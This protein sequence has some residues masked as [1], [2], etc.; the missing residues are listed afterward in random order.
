MNRLQND[1]LRLE[2]FDIGANPASTQPAINITASLDTGSLVMLPGSNNIITNSA[3]FHMEKDF[4]TPPDGFTFVIE[5][6]NVDSLIRFIQRGWRVRVSLNN[7]Y[8]MIGYVYHINYSY[9]KDGTRLT[10][11]CKDLLECLAQATVY[12]NLGTTSQTNYHFGYSATLQDCLQDIADAFCNETGFDAI[13]VTADNSADLKTASGFNFG[14]KGTTDTGLTRSLNHLTT[15]YPGESHLAYMNR[16]AQHAGR[17]LKMSATDPSTIIC[18]A[19]TYDRLNGSPFQLV[20]YLNAP[21]N[22]ENNIKAA[23]YNF[24]WDR[25]PTVVITDI[26]TQGDDKFY[27]GNVKGVAINEL[28]GYPSTFEGSGNPNPIYNVRQAITVLTANGNYRDRSF[29]NDL[30]RMRQLFPIDLSTPLNFPY[31]TLDGSAHNGDEAIYG[32]SQL[33][34]QA[35]DQYLE[36][37][38]KVQGW[39]YQGYVWQP[40]TMVTVID[41]GLNPNGTQYTFPMW[42]RKI[43]YTMS[44][45][46]G[47]E[48]HLTCTLPFT[49]SYQI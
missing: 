48:T 33:L 31:Y 2:F 49:H 20:H 26:Q 28:T 40:D 44:K 11:E 38:Y 15:P 35:Q 9:D 17:N 1:T 23:S 24:N 36:V 45:Q 34:A 16:L 12:P 7:K 13:T 46:N 14:L 5:D 19:P 8:N 10:I 32:A 43:N 29:N 25:Q 22:Q 6:N 42:I 18:S 21:S 47:T 4:F 39:T 41:Q 3:S 37:I 30:Y 27:Q